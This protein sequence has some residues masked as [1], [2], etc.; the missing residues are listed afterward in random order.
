MTQADGRYAHPQVG[1]GVILV[2][3]QGQ[4]LLGRRKNSHAPYWSIPGGHLE[5]GET[6]EACAS[7]EVAEETGIQIHAPRV[8]AVSNNLATYAESGRH[9]IS[10]I[11]L[12]E[13]ITQ[14][15]RLME[16]DKCEGWHWC[17]PQCPPQPH[18]DASA[19]ALACWQQGQPYLPPRLTENS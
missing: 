11:L 14:A 5:L 17:D 18:F 8:I 7:R 6:F 1:I 2:N 4:V 16:P 15:P 3:P 12:A 10:V 13:G 9:Y 19:Q